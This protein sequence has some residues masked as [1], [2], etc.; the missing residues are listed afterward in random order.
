MTEFIGK[1]NFR[2][3]KCQYN[4]IDYCKFE[5]KCRT[6]HA[7][8]VCVKKNCNKDCNFR[9]PIPCKYDN[10]CKFHVNNV[11][12]FSHA[13]LKS[14]AVDKLC[15]GSSESEKWSRVSETLKWKETVRTWRN[16][17]RGKQQLRR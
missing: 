3:S 15:K 8:N 7:R 16:R 2:N 9:H 1:L 17:E 4:D 10:R 5:D 14:G 13:K 6:E 12:A 11:C